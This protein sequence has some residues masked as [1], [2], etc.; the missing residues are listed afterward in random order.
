MASERAKRYRD[1]ATEI[2]P[3]SALSGWM[4]KLKDMHIPCFISP[5]HDKDVNPDGEPKKPHYHIM[6]M[7][8][9]VKTREQAIEAFKE[10]EGVGCEV[11]NSRRG[12]ARY[13]IH[14]DNPEKY[15]YD[16]KDVISLSGADY[17][18]TISLVSDKYAVLNDVI[19]F[20]KDNN[21]DNVLDLY[22]YAVENDC[23]DWKR[24][25]QDKS[26]VVNMFCNANYQRNKDIKK[27]LNAKELEDWHNRLNER[28][29]KC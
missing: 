19:M 8:T 6:M 13:L 21:I 23:L 27:A 7:H 1:F 17:Y 25:I 4:D 14:K 9:S 18:E 10:I 12:Y 16:E 3:E 2:Y 24:I 22:N 26:F 11:I 29:N 5:L 15:Q 20:I 28:E